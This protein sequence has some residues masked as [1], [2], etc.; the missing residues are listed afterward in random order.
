MASGDWYYVHDGARAG[1][2]SA[3]EIAR[4]LEGGT[5][6][7]RS[8]IWREGLDGWEQAGAHFDAPQRTPP[9]PVPGAPPPMP[10]VRDI[11]R[12]GTRRGADVDRNSPDGEIQIGSDGLY[13]G[14]PARGF[15]EAISVCL[16]S[17]FTF[18]GRAS[19]SEYWYFFLFGVLAGLVTGVLDSILFDV[20]FDS[21][22]FGPLNS[23]TSLVLLIPS[24]AVS[25]RR[26][27]DIDRSG[28][29]IGGFFIAIMLT[30]V[31]IG[32]AAVSGGLEG[33]IGMIGLL[34]IGALIYTIVMLVF[35]CTRGNPGPNRFG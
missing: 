25:W 13:I 33:M 4:R 12:T 16:S 32:L 11:P 6:S 35:L 18:S 30:G 14:A 10:G 31:M 8:L 17:Y 26:L 7:P 29:W 22:D 24:L 28:W 3:E 2:V 20:S 5:L 15:A 21:E 34:G 27:H 23:L 1:P 19:R 9:P